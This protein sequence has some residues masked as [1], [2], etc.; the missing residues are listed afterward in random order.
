[1]IEYLRKQVLSTSNELLGLVGKLLE[2][3]DT[4]DLVNIANQACQLVGFNKWHCAPMPGSFQALDAMAFGLGTW[5]EV[6]YQEYFKRGFLWTDPIRRVVK[7]S[8][9]PIRWAD[10]EYLVRTPQE[11]IVLEAAREIGMVDGLTIP[12]HAAHGYVAAVSWTSDAPLS[13]DQAD[14]DMMVLFSI[15]FHERVAR[16]HGEALFAGNEPVRLS[17]RERDILSWVLEGKSNADIGDILG[18]SVNTVKFHLKQVCTRLSVG[19]RVQAAVRALVTGALGTPS[20]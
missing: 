20:N 16:I 9:Q 5:G 1:L 13:L 3:G 15:Y 7:F 17:V 4:D 18:I 2:S 19:T 14:A 6:W 8:N 12:I 10:A 11:R